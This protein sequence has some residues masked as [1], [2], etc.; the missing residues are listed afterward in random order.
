MAVDFESVFAVSGTDDLDSRGIDHKTVIQVGKFTDVDLR[1][2]G[3]GDVAT[4]IDMLLDLYLSTGRQN[5]DI[6]F[7]RY[8]PTANGQCPS[9][10]A[11]SGV[12][13]ARTDDGTGGPRTW[14]IEAPAGALACMYTIHGLDYGDFDFGP[15][16]LSLTEQF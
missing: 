14:T 13:V 9:S 7:V 1:A 4:N 8:S 3:P 10:R 16:I 15:F 12:T 2:L 5:N 11:T 6:L